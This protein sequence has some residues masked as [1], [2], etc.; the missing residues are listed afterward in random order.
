MQVKKEFDALKQT[1]QD[2]QHTQNSLRYSTEKLIPNHQTNEKLETGHREAT[3]ELLKLKDRAIEL[4][5]N[6][7]LLFPVI[8][9]TSLVTMSGLLGPGFLSLQESGGVFWST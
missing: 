3:M 7:S 5:R 9:Q 8:P 6:V 2:G 4:E 1:Q